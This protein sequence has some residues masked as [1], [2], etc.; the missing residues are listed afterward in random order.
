MPK[1]VK[2]GM[3]IGLAIITAAII[4][5]STLEEISTKTAI[6][7]TGENPSSEKPDIDN[8]ILSK[9]NELRENEEWTDN[10]LR[11]QTMGQYYTVKKGDTLGDIAGRFYGS[12]NLWR[13]IYNANSNVLK[14]PDDIKP[15]MKLFI[16]L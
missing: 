9:P 7:E 12:K 15:G 6:L 3:M 8:T 11:D 4:W 10:K 5:L 1:D 16:P 13:R 14:S 2:I